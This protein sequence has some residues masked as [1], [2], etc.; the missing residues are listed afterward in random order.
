MNRICVFCGANPGNDPAFAAA[1]RELGRT[2]V[3]QG[4]ELVFGGSNVGLMREIADTVLAAGG[5]AVG[6]IPGFLVDREK[7][8]Q[9]LSELHVVDTMHERKA[10]MVQ[11]ADGF[12]ALPGGLGTLD[13]TM[14]ILS[15][16]QLGLHDKPC[17]LFNVNGYF[18]LLIEFLDHAVAHGFI[19]AEHRRILVA[20]SSPGELLVGLGVRSR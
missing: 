14:E 15:W 16:A 5:T 4:L 9:G 6:V 3:E 1:A 20:E 19:R 17:G 11:L 18:D 12:V 13:E 8:H 2:L 7:A 10:L